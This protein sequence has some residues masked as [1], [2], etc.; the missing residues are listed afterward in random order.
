MVSLHMIENDHRLNP[1]SC[2]LL[3]IEKRKYF[4]KF[5]ESLYI[6]STENKMNISKG[7]PVNAISCSTLVNFLKFPNLSNNIS[8]Q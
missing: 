7:M 8:R 5:K 2:K 1:S 6:A 4:R 3:N